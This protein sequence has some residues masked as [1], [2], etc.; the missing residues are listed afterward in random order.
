MQILSI[1]KSAAGDERSG[2][3]PAEY[4]RAN[5]RRDANKAEWLKRANAAERTGQLVL[6]QNLRHQ[7]E[8]C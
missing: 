1:Q 2:H 4:I 5:K 8:I 6:A 7:A 3:D